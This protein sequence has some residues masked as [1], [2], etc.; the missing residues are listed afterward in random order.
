MSLGLVNTEAE[1]GK[2][3]DYDSGHSC[4]ESF[5]FAGL[6]LVIRQTNHVL[7]FELEY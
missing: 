7:N 2:K 3:A 4:E 1:D 5:H 6:E